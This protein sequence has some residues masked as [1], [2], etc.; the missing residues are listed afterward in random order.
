MKN[1]TKFI[2][3]L[4]YT[5]SIFFLPNNMLILI[6]LILNL[7][8]IIICKLR[9]G[10]IFSKTSNILPFIIFT[11]II[12]LLLD[13]LNNAIWVSI[14]LFIVCNTTIIYSEKETITS[15]SETIEKLCYPLR[16]FSLKENEVKVIV[17]ISLSMIPVLKKQLNEIKEV[18]ISKN[19]YLNLK[20]IKILMVKFFYLI[21][22]RINQIDEALI[23]KQYY[24]DE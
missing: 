2:I 12:N 6:C 8:V 22:N 24:G 20:N 9:V 21:I 1:V 5:T 4:A 15:I 14:K 16:F 17:G 18:I 3:F 23:A 11:F 7:L 10:K 19:M 13:D